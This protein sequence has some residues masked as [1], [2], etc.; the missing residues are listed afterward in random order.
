[1][2]RWRSETERLRL[3]RPVP[4]GGRCAGG[5]SLLRLLC[6]VVIAILVCEFVHADDRFRRF[7]PERRSEGPRHTTALPTP[8]QND[9]NLHDVQFVG[10]ATGFAVGDHGV[11]W[12]TTD[13]GRTWK[14]LPSPVDC[15]LRSLCFLT[16]RIGW[17]AGGGT[18]PYTRLGYGVVLHTQ[19]GGRSWQVLAGRRPQNGQQPSGQQNGSGPN[20]ESTFEPSSRTKADSPRRRSDA[21]RRTSVAE[22]S[23][24]RPSASIPLPSLVFVRFFDLQHGVA[25]GEASQHAP[26]GVLTTTDGGATWNP[27]PGRHLPGWRAADFLRLQVG[28]VAG[29][30]G[31]LSVVGGGRMLQPAADDLGLR[32]VKDLVLAADETGWLV[33]EGGLVLKTDNGGVVWKAPPESLPLPIRDFVDFHAVAVHE[34]NVWIAGSPGSVIWHSSDGGRTWSRQ[35]TG[36]TVPIHALHFSNNRRGWAVGALGTML[37]TSDG[38][39]TWVARRGGKRRAAYMAVPT[40]PENVSFPLLATLSKDQGFRGTI[41]V[42]ARGDFGPDGA[43][44]IPQDQQLAEAVISAG[45]SAGVMHWRFPVA[46]PG[47]DRNEQRLWQDWNLRAEGRLREVMLSSLVAQLRTWKPDVVILDAAHN[48]DA[49]AKLVNQAM[50]QATRRAG[51]PTSFIHHAE[52]AGLKPWTVSKIYVRLTDGSAGDASISSHAY[53]EHAGEVTHLA[54]APAEAK[55]KSPSP[56]TSRQQAYRLIFDRTAKPAG[57]PGAS[58]D[59]TPKH[60]GFFQGLSLWPGTAARRRLSPVDEQQTKRQRLLARRQ[61]NFHA[62][63]ERTRDDSRFAAQMVAQL[64]SLTDGMDAERAAAQW[65]SLAE[66][67]RRQSRWDLAEATWIETVMQYPTARASLTA[68]QR[69]FLLWTGAEPVWH[70]VQRVAVHRRQLQTETPKL[71]QRLQ[72]AIRLARMPS[73]LRH[74]ARLDMRTDPATFLSEPKPA[75]FDRNAQRQ[76]KGIRHWRNQALRMASLIRKRDPALYL[77]PRIQFPLA[78]LLRSRG[79]LRTAQRSYQR[80][81]QRGEESAWKT[82]A[83]SEIWLL[84]PQGAPP[85]PVNICTPAEARPLLDGVL[86]DAC[87]ENAKPIWLSPSR[88]SGEELQRKAFVLCTYDSHY[89]YLAANVPRVVSLKQSD[90]ENESRRPRDADL[91]RFDRVSI[92][93]DL[94]RDY[95]TWFTLSV[96]QRGWTADSCWGDTSWNP[97]WYVAADSGHKTWRFE[98]A[99][100]LKEL[101]PYPLKRRDLWA[102]GIVRTVPALGVQS[103]THPA[104]KRPQPET[105]GLLRFD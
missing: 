51:D 65:L 72:R 36:N 69:L 97:K 10:T 94:D 91:S 83:D 54:A 100:P 30:H 74:V 42:T 28:A 11:I 16:D 62:I 84:A 33:G 67:Y 13:G 43:T 81:Q 70:R 15:P 98:A 56:Q 48:G 59:D 76:H 4:G 24:S 53:L 2:A 38:G 27:V 31:R 8:L 5:Q 58:A 61:R 102:V 3:F 55:L 39:T 23:A 20:M 9:A 6:P 96:D 66:D 21:R 73:P 45:G 49:L 22:P 101:T 92:H 104:E 44:G 80:F 32:G 41:L 75:A 1:M 35:R 50:L 63:A 19:D 99:I 85:K 26:S 29:L 14:L 79:A 12:K 86:S 34:G 47:L 68:M 57:T 60:R 64:N 17:I 105:F 77:S 7:Y 78:A 95:A 87:W 52:L 90:K 40:R 89:L 93:L 18:T 88:E 46:L 103:W 71:R 37:T 25:V 82:A